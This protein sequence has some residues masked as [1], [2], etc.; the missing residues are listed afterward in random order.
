LPWNALFETPTL[1]ENADT[2]EQFVL[3][4]YLP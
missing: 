1:R 4:F 3:D 2:Y